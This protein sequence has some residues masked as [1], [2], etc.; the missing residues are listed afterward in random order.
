M[1]CDSLLQFVKTAY[2]ANAEEATNQ[3]LIATLLSFLLLHK[4]VIHIY[5]HISKDKGIFDSFL[6]LNSS[7][8]SITISNLPRY[9][10]GGKKQQFDLIY[11]GS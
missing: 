1:Y 2:M 3:K 4:V 7:L 6:S 10:A 9:C 11:Q 5:I 8:C